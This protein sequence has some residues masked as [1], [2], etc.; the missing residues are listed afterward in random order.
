[1]L[2]FPPLTQEHGKGPWEK[3]VGHL[4]P[5]APRSW[6]FLPALA[7]ATS[8]GF[9]LAFLAHLSFL[10]LFS[11][12]LFKVHELKWDQEVLC[13]QA[14]IR[15][16]RSRSGASNK[17]ARFSLHEGFRLLEHPWLDSDGRMRSPSMGPHELA[18]GIQDAVDI[19]E[20][21]DGLSPRQTKTHTD[22]HMAGAEG[23]TIV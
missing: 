23:G 5:H 3:R 19:D 14:P 9:N 7:Q 22:V 8:A 12:F 21:G 1:M 11:S 18:G 20:G 6:K 4:G 13:R 15:C 16:H 10:F 2:S 17:E